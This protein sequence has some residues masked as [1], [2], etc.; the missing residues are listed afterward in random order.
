MAGDAHFMTMQSLIHQEK[1][2]LTTRQ[3]ML[4]HSIRA[5]APH[6][7]QHKGEIIRVLER[8]GIDYDPK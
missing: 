6:R 5:Q 2:H 7:G 4:P 1:N 3:G 8:R